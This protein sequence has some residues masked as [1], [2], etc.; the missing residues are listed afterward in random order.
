MLSVTTN[1]FDRISVMFRQK[2]TY[3]I[4]LVVTESITM[5]VSNIVFIIRTSLIK[6]FITM[7]R[8]IG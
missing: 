1:S 4:T 2:D 6:Y 7:V 3:V 5:E 8:P